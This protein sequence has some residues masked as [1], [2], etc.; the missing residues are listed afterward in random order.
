MSTEARALPST[1]G[2]V[3][4]TRRKVMGFV[5]LGI[6]AAIWLIFSRTTTP[7]VITTFTLN[8][9]GS[10]NNFP[11]WVF[12]TLSA[13]NIIAGLCA[14]MGAY[15]LARGFGK[16]TNMVLGL[17][18]GG[19]ILA[20][21]SWSA[22]D[23]SLNLAGLLRSTLVRAVPITLGALSGVLCERAGVVNIAI[24]GM[25]LASAMTAA[26]GGSLALNWME[27]PYN[28]WFGLVV[29]VL[30]GGLLALVHALLS[31]K[32]KADQI[33]SGTVINI[34]A[35]GI[36]SFISAKYLAKYRYLNNP[37]I[38][39]DWKI[40]G[41][42][43]IPFFGPI[44]FDHNVFFFGMVTF[45]ILLH[46]GLFFTRW[47]LRLRSVGEHPKVAD[48]LGI[49]VFKTRYMAVVL[50]GMMAGFGGSYFTL[51]SVGR[52]DEVMTAGRGFI[53]LAAMIFGNW[54]PF[55]SFG[56]GLLFGFA[57]MLA[58]KLAILGVK[59]PSEFLLMAPY[60]ATMIVLAGVVGRGKMPAA[61]GQPYEK[62]T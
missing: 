44:V 19:F 36:T 21:L 24:E 29:G 31:I 57:D 8:P 28:L 62:E 33:V 10:Q 37:G 9:G 54:K 22:A 6:A 1:V 17:V 30:T 16:S 15:Q 50:G 56:A 25:M 51:G 55:G 20:F 23:N 3:S 47:G 14:L 42:S 13:L 35:I 34:F 45:L 60:V 12:T 32:Y 27:P 48:T 5:F 7:G 46:F 43:D 38:F 49:N 61:D 26:L 58:S 53:G 59:I 41:L 39:S 11:D 52:F 18:A 2:F 40:P 4:P